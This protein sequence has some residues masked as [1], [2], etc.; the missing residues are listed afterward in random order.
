MSKYLKRALSL[1]SALMLS[2]CVDAP[3]TTPQVAQVRQPGLGLTGAAAPHFPSQWWKAFKD[4]QLDRLIDLVVSENPTLQGALAKLRAAQAELAI[5]RAEYWPQVTLDGGEQRILF[6]RSYIIRPPFGGSY[7]WSGSLAAN[8]SWDL[9]FWGKQAVLIA[10]ARST[11][12]ANAF[13]AEA[14]RLALS[15]AFAQAYVDLLLNYRN[16]DIADATVT[17]RTEILQ[18]TKGRFDAGLEDASAVEEARS[19]LSLAKADQLRYSAAREVDIHAIAAL[20]GQGA[21]LYKTIVRPN[22]DLDVALHLPD[23]LPADLLARRPDILA[24]KA[25]VEA[26]V[27]GRIA[28]HADFY[29]DINLSALIG[30]QS[31]GLADMF[32]GNA[33]TAAIGPALHLPIFDAGKLRAQYAFATADLDSS[34]ADYNRTVVDAIRQTADALTGV[35]S[36]TAQRGHQQ[37]AVKSAQRAYVIARERYRSGLATQLPTL[38]AEATLL[39]ARRGLAGVV[40]DDA[41]LRI[42]LLLTVGGGF[43]PPAGSDAKI[44]KQDIRHD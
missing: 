31:I 15:G 27:Q 24:A 30:F 5:N 11:A 6:S 28:A 39:E 2:A 9:D 25:R 4:P 8:L 34:V 1:I 18:I 19:L 13:D 32:T 37:D 14:A 44:A 12:E 40:A 38:T 16:G 10:K 42:T 33:L 7:R 41:K 21:A 17:E 26:A 35:E 23:K 29:P 20:A 36:L 22:P 3:P 43:E